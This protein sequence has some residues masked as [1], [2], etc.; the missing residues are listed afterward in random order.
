MASHETRPGNFSNAG[1]IVQFAVPVNPIQTGINLPQPRE[2]LAA[3]NDLKLDLTT[4][5]AEALNGVHEYLNAA[6]CPQPAKKKHCA[7]GTRLFLRQQGTRVYD[8]VSCHLDRSNGKTVAN[9]GIADNGSVCDI[10][11]RETQQEVHHS[12]IEPWD[13]RPSI[14]AVTV[15]VHGNAE[16]APGNQR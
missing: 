5:F 9:E 2:V 15:G 14:Y 11:F 1:G 13:P 12:A 16:N 6:V 10:A 7:F 4:R 8:G 3:S